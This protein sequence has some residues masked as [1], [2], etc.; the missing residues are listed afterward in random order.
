M[1]KTKQVGAEP[2]GPG[3]GGKGDGVMFSLSLLAMETLSE[4]HSVLIFCSS[5]MMTVDTAVL[6]AT[7]VLIVEID[8][9]SHQRRL[10][11]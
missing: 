1:Q 8:G 9:L 6:F 7:A 3:K 5:R 11:S 4:G 10:G 2:P